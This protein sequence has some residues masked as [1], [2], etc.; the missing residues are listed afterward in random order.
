MKRHGYFGKIY[1]NEVIL[2]DIGMKAS[3]Y[4]SQI[5]NHFPHVKID[6]YVI[7]PNHIHGILILDYSISEPYHD[8]IYHKFKKSQFSK[9]VKNSVSI[10]TNQ[11]KSSLKRWCNKNGLSFF[12]WQESFYDEILHDDNALE[13]ARAYIL[14]NPQNWIHDEFYV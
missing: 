1:D 9:P 6:K 7:M 10:I 3:E 2:S 11:Y 12:N 8:Q 5:S 14:N 4:W 13:N